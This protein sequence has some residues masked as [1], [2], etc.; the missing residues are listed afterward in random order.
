ME[1]QRDTR[2]PQ[3]PNTYSQEGDR[4]RCRTGLMN[5]TR[6]KERKE[7]GCAVSLTHCKTQKTSTVQV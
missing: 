4:L 3:H 7:I 5:Q 1:D 2:K 6:K